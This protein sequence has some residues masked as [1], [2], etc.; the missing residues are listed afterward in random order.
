MQL[1]LARGGGVPSAAAGVSARDLAGR[2]GLPTNGITISSTVAGSFEPSC[3]HPLPRISPHSAAFSG[4]GETHEGVTGCIFTSQQALNYLIQTGWVPF[5]CRVQS[6]WHSLL[7]RMVSGSKYCMSP[8]LLTMWSLACHFH[9]PLM[10]LLPA[11][12]WAHPP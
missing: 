7:G 1:S 11:A 10:W 3:V 9:P 12:A 2:T 4:T 5:F 8:E 6:G